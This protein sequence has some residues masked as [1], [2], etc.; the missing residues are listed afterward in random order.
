VHEQFVAPSHPLLR[1]VDDPEVQTIADNRLTEQAVPPATTPLGVTA[2][3]TNLK[4]EPIGRRETV[5][6]GASR[7]DIAMGPEIADFEGF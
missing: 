6:I 7:R 5:M 1:M 2:E 3:M 4:V